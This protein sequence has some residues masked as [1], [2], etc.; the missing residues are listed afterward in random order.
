[1]TARGIGRQPRGSIRA[2]VASRS[3]IDHALIWAQGKGLLRPFR[4]TRTMRGGG[5]RLRIPIAHGVGTAHLAG[6]ERW[7]APL[8]RLLLR[9]AGRG[10]FVDVGANVGQ[11][12]VALKQVAPDVAYIGLEPNPA[13]A[14]YL[15][16]LVAANRWER[17]TIVPAAL[18]SAAGVVRLTFFGTD[19]ADDT[20][21]TCEGVRPASRAAG[22]MLVPQLTWPA[23]EA[24]VG[25]PGVAVVKVDV[26]GSELEVLQGM[27]AMLAR[28]R[29]IVLCEVLPVYT[30]GNTARLERQRALEALLTR[31]L[32]YQMQRV[33]K[34]AGGDFTGLTPIDE[35]GIHGDLGAC[36]YVFLQP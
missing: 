3:V 26:E 8:L 4:F 6:H 31:E 35:I 13:A 23:V 9:G 33:L 29:P 17:C 25:G 28:D 20:A 15:V 27:R 2:P 22:E 30:A 14:S 7:M 36:D 10:A 32:G 11:T 5:E 16:A 34:S 18:G 1:M 19:P 21:S 12:L 24:A